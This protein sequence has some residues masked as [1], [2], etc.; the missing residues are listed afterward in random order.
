M[1]GFRGT[2]G[3]ALVVTLWVLLILSMLVSAF[4]F[5]MHVEAS[6]SSYYRKRVKAVYLARAGA[7][8]A[9]M[10]LAKSSQVSEEDLPGED[11]Q[12]F[13]SAMNLKRGVAVRGVVQEL[14]EGS[15][16]V[17][18]VPEEGRRNVNLLTDEDWEEVLDQA[19]V[20]PED[21]PELI[22]AFTDWVDPGDEHRLNGAESD[23]PFY[24][25]RGYKVKN[26]AL[27]TVD[28]LLLIK[29]FSPAIVYGGLP[30]DGNP[31]DEP[32]L[33]IASW[34]T[35]WGD[36][37]VNLNTASR[38]VLMTLPDMD[39]F[40]VDQIVEG[41]SGLDGEIG[42]RDDGFDSV[43]EVLS[44]TGLDPSLKDKVSVTDRTYVRVVSVGEV[45]SVRRGIW[46][47]FRVDDSGASPVF[48]REEA[49]P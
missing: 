18:I 9:R 31:D 46:C 29:G 40:A 6:V 28:E 23:D 20:P 7:E 2:R 4:A 10:V 27:D 1:T 41:R 25:E 36:G 33:G 13:V 47:I 16:E 3:S 35:T 17:D 34:L 32:L 30:E 22:D 14:G 45:Q 11:E 12:L 26:A 21:W 24:E 42:T 39:E 37:K 5:D 49:M 15:F 44:L 48:W 8:W 43:D 38:E 19:H